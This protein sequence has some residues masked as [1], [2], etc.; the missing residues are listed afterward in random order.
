MTTFLTVYFVLNMLLALGMHA[1]TLRST[2]ERPSTAESLLYFVIFL[3]VG[4]PL[5]MTAVL[6]GAVSFTAGKKKAQKQTDGSASTL[7][8]LR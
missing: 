2:L 7:F 1:A 6:F 4:L 3:V 8:L 5:M